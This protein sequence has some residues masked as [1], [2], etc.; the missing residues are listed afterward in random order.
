MFAYVVKAIFPV[1]SNDMLSMVVYHAGSKRDV[2]ALVSNDGWKVK[3]VSIATMEDVRELGRFETVRLQVREDLEKHRAMAAETK[4]RAIIETRRREE[5]HRRHQ[6]AQEREAEERRDYAIVKATGDLLNVELEPE[7]A[8]NTKVASICAK[9]L[10]FFDQASVNRRD[11]FTAISIDFAD[12]QSQ[13]DCPRAVQLLSTVLNELNGFLGLDSDIARLQEGLHG[14]RIS[15]ENQIN[16]ISSR[17]HVF[18]GSG[19]GLIISAL[20]ADSAVRQ[21]RKA[22]DSLGS[23]YNHLVE[24]V[25]RA[26]EQKRMQ[27]QL[28]EYRA[29]TAVSMLLVA[30]GKS[31]TI[32]VNMPF[33]VEQFVLG[34]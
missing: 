15:A 24:Q 30:C 14:E 11:L 27:Q 8:G 2:E 20:I 7:L 34:Q 21:D 26:A 23:S 9:T 33:A 17:S 1:L 25:T 19:E 12:F 28:L 6:A 18:G 16:S 3:R 13:F 4:R 22:I 31:K 32:E 29:K 5:E 10:L